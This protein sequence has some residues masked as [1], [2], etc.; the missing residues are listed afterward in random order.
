MKQIT[1]LIKIIQK[2]FKLLLRSKFSSLIIILGPLFLILLLGIA[3]NNTNSMALNIGVYSEEYTDTVNI[4]TDKLSEKQYN[5]EK[6]SSELDCINKIKINKLNACVIFPP[7]LDLE[8]GIGNNTLTFYVDNSRINMVFI[9]IEAL[10]SKFSEK[11]K[12]ISMDLTNTL[13]QKLESTRV[14]IFNKKPL[15][16]EIKKLNKDSTDKLEQIKIDLNSLDIS[17]N[18]NDFKTTETSTKL[19]EI[20]KQ[21]NEIEKAGAYFVDISSHLEDIESDVESL[22]SEENSASISDIKD[23][24]NTTQSKVNEANTLIE[25]QQTNTDKKITELKLLIKDINLNIEKTK[26]K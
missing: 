10:S 24:I 4:F 6:T 8:K 3:F 2:N 23:L 7:N 1:P 25:D 11:S 9:I 13:L 21:N 22:E 16:S 5:V 15:L 12:E 19:D 20:E 14:E 26:N 18:T 17:I